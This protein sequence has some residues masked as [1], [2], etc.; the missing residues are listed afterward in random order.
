M[1]MKMM[2]KQESLDKDDWEVE[3]VD[4]DEDEDDGN[5]DVV[6][7]TIVFEICPILLQNVDYKK[8]VTTNTTAVMEKTKEKGALGNEP[9]VEV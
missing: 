9:Y 4:E 2:G 6:R 3:K 5:D 7:N 1:R 8:K